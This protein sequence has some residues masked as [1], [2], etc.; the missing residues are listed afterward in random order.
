MF[1]DDIE[2]MFS[3]AGDEVSVRYKNTDF[4]GFLNNEFVEVPAGRSASQGS[5]PILY[6][7]SRY[8]AHVKF[9]D[10]ILVDKQTYEIVGHQPDG[11]G[12]TVLVINDDKA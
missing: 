10:A 12:V 6:V 11:T 1:E 2:E 8:V 7:P 9:G 5:S 4:T 3:G